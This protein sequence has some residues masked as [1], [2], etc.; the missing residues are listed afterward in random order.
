MSSYTIVGAKAPTPILFF[1]LGSKT[2]I[3]VFLWREAQGTV[4][5]NKVK[6]R[7]CLTYCCKGGPETWRHAHFKYLKTPFSFSKGTSRTPSGGSVP[8]SS[9]CENPQFIRILVLSKASPAH[10]LGRP[11]ISGFLVSTIF[12]SDLLRTSTGMTS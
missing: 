6:Q 3:Y 2:I 10:N 7:H 12:K 5:Y 8:R 4:S 1:Y 9:P 11:L